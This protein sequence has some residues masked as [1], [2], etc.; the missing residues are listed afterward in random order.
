[1]QIQSKDLVTFKADI[2]IDN[3]IHYGED[4]TL[5]TIE[6]S[7]GGAL[8]QVLIEPGIDAEDVWEEFSLSIPEADDFCI[9]DT[10]HRDNCPLY[11][12]NT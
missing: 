7:S 6:D 3:H 11:I 5:M 8:C 1:M 12:A 9:T 2:I 10:E 4:Y